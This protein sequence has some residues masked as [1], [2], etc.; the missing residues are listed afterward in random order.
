MLNAYLVLPLVEPLVGTIGVE[1]ILSVLQT[2]VSYHLHQIPKYVQQISLCDFRRSPLQ[3]LAVVLSY[4]LSNTDGV[5]THNFLRERQV[6]YPN[7]STVSC[8]CRPASHS[9]S[10]L[11]FG[12]TDTSE[13]CILFLVFPPSFLSFL[14]A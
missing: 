3:R 2:D 11:L 9:N 12:S 6:T 10:D 14:G 1:P 5:R 7:L 4:L 8:F 13:S